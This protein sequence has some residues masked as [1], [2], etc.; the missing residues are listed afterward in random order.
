M[1]LISYRCLEVSV[2]DGVPR[3]PH[4]MRA[5][6]WVHTVRVSGGGRDT[7]TATTRN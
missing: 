6:A 3:A 7:F 4:G 5:M 2:E 1:H